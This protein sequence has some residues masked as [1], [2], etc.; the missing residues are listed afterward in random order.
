M[1]RVDGKEGNEGEAI[2][3]EDTRMGGE[4]FDEEACARSR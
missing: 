1:T 4:V 2:R 3:T